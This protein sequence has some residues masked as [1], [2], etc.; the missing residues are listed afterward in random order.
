MILRYLIITITV[1]LSLFLSLGF[2]LLI[3][4]HR[5]A[6]KLSS[7]LSRTSCHQRLSSQIR[8][9]HLPP[10]AP[11]IF[12]QTTPLRIEETQKPPQIAP[13]KSICSRIYLKLRNQLPLQKVNPCTVNH[14]VLTL[15]RCRSP[16]FKHHPPP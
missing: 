2:I 11:P 4:S 7:S 16:T 9:Y 3:P 13:K 14:H 1:L 10:N 5:Q 8:S 6:I 12:D 15:P